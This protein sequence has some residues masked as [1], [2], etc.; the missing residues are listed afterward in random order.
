MRQE[1]D[2]L[3]SLF[4]ARYKTGIHMHSPLP[5]TGI[6]CTI[7]IR[8][9]AC[10][11]RLPMIHQNCLR[12]F[13]DI[14]YDP[15]YIGLVEDVT[16]GDRLAAA[17]GNNRIMLHGNHGIIVAAPNV[18]QVCAADRYVSIVPLTVR[19]LW[20]TSVCCRRLLT[21]GWRSLQKHVQA[22]A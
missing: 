15:V 22:Y 5:A 12:Y 13:N 3:L 1:Q 11:G 18:W 16:E 17:M 20:I 14:A 8:L 4:V 6:L 2:V 7:S 21:I 19:L 10:C 9:C